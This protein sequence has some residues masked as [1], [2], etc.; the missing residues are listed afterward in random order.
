MINTSGIVPVDM[1]VL[2]KPEK[3]SEKTAGGVFIPEKAQDKQKFAGTKAVLVA[4][5]SNA[6]VEWGSEA[7]KPAPGSVVHYAQYT[8]SWIT[9]ED[10]ED[11]VIMNDKDLTSIVEATNV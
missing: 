11:Y 8:G 7:R 1:R 4:I 3:P 2:V 10:G 6:F 5:G 9:G